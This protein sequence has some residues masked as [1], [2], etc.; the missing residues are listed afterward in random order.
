MR[1]FRPLMA[2]ICAVAL[3]LPA[4]PRAAAAAVDTSA[5]ELLSSSISPA[6]LDLTSGPG[7]VTVTVRTSDPSGVQ[8]PGVRLA[9]DTTTQTTGVGRM[10]LAGGT[11]ADGTWTYTF[12]LPQGA[13]PGAWTAIVRPLA[14]VLGNSTKTAHA[15][16][17][18]TVQSP[19]PGDFSAP[20][21]VSSSVQPQALDVTSGPGT[22]TVTA[23]V[24][25]PSGTAPTVRL[26]HPTTFQRLTHVSRTLVSGTP[27]DGV[28]Q[29]A[30]A[31]PQGAAPGEWEAMMDPLID[32]LG[33]STRFYTL[34]ATLTVRSTVV[35]STSPR[36]HSSSVSPTA[37]D[38]ADGPH[39]VTVTIRLSDPSGVKTPTVEL[40]NIGSNVRQVGLGPM[41][42][43]SGTTTDGTWT[44]TITIPQG[45]APGLWTANVW[46]TSDTLGNSGN[47]IELGQFSVGQLWTT[48]ALT[49]SSPR[50]FSASPITLTGRVTPRQATGTITFREG[51]T[52]IGSCT[53][54]DGWCQLTTSA[55]PVGSRTLTASYSGD[56][57]FPASASQ[58]V[59]HTVAPKAS[60]SVD[61][62]V[63]INPVH[64]YGKASYIA[65]VSPTTATGRVSFLSGPTALGTCELTG[66][67][68][69]LDVTWVGAGN[70]PVTA[71]Y[72]G[73]AAVAGSTSPKVV[74]T[75]VQM[76]PAAPSTNVIGDSTGDR[77]ADVYA[78][79]RFGVTQ[80]FAGS[81]TGGLRHVGPRGTNLQ[82]MTYIAQVKD[83]NGDRQPDVIA[84]DIYGN[85]FTFV[86]G[87]NGYV[88]KS[89]QIGWN[90]NGMDKIV[91]VGN[92][93]GGTTQYLLARRAADGSL[94]R[95]EFTAS[96][97]KNGVQIGQHWNGMVQLI[98]VGDKGSDGYADLLAIRQDGTLWSY[99]GE[100]GGRLGWG[101]PVGRGW[102]TFTGAFSAGDL[103]LD[104]RADLIGRR[105]DGTVWA[106]HNL[107]NGQ[108]S[109]ARRI[110]SGF[111]DYGLMG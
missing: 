109:Y 100:P 41:T 13:A 33:N 89:H 29:V 108:W 44:R 106:Y 53:V 103:N 36:V 61:L 49:V 45:A 43:A 105:S 57:R 77:V 63:G 21:L 37:I 22:V 30:F 80:F 9:S 93:G 10:T 15:V 56:A 70:H 48:T 66:G 7:E 68:C 12:T 28:W 82:D 25:D 42:L 20:Q 65:V 79:D 34:L 60:S 2:A 55:L 71:S 107:P 26:N 87:G 62:K 98:G 99:R 88:S 94:W 83:L 14:D 90:W 104:G 101:V 27:A 73:N 24:S 39:D 1:H 5:P 74:Q 81:P 40:N 95:Y 92:L 85:L 78:V 38:P 102:Y 84:R 16:G 96:G 4:A 111:G 59:T 76:L 47:F 6:I 54:S 75:V 69:Q 91:P 67:R 31:V 32:G 3:L 46:Q 19:G 58:T 18:F 97:L 110:G 8:V 51:T 23:H 64:K 50:S 35:D 52:T 86:S 72:H 17:R 11:A